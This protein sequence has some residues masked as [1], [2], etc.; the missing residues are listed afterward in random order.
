MSYSNAE[1]L[2]GHPTEGLETPSKTQ[3]SAT[4]QVP[5]EVQQLK[6][7]SEYGLD[8]TLSQTFPCSAPL[9]S[10]PNPTTC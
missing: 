9:S 2:P 8:N 3:Q 7:R 1:S 10:I 5:G 4:N 6:E